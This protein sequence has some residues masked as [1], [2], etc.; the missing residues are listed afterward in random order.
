MVDKLFYFTSP[1]SGTFFPMSVKMEFYFVQMGG[2]LLCFRIQTLLLGGE[3]YVFRNILGKRHLKT[4]IS[5]PHD[6]GRA[7][8]WWN[9]KKMY[10]FERS[11]RNIR[12]HTAIWHP[13]CSQMCM[14][15]LGVLFYFSHTKTLKRVSFGHRKTR[16]NMEN[17]VLTL[18]VF[19]RNALSIKHPDFRVFRCPK[20]TR[21]SVLVWLK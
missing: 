12:K 15:N 10:I 14:L 2:T 4:A 18:T 6:L 8:R 17:M 9:A 20:L 16:E 3:G 7:Q 11:F 5:K 1:A 19:S 13:T 21:V